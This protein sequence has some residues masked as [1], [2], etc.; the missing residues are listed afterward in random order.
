M[1][2]FYRILWLFFCCSFLGWVGETAVAAI[3]E[4]K[5]VD[6]SLLFGPVCVIYGLS[7]LVITV[8]LR[9]LANG[10]FSLFLGSAIYSTVAEWLAGHLLEKLTGTR[11]WDYS[12]RKWN[13]DGYI[14]LETSALWGLLGLAAVKW[15]L[16]MLAELRLMFPPLVEQIFLWAALGVFLVDCLATGLT[17]TGL[18]HKLPAVEQ[19]G[20]R[21]EAITLRMGVWV[22]HR[23]ER[24]IQKAHPKADFRREKKK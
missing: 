4:H 24:R 21:L 7:G 14:C 3:K 11:W 9:D 12:D 17:L 16:P 15:I 18:V 8:V 6:R 5:Y 20:S 1:E 10:W 23:T 22:L 2:L 19:A 13:L